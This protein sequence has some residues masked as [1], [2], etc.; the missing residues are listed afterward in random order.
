MNIFLHQRHIL[1]LLLCLFSLPLWGQVEE[2]I[3]TRPGEAVDYTFFHYRGFP[4]GLGTLTEPQHGTII[5]PVLVE[6]TEIFK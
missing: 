6:G 4:I 3:E 5:G 2:R 1:L